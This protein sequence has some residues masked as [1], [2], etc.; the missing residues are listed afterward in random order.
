MKEISRDG[1]IWKKRMKD[2]RIKFK[3]FHL[4]FRLEMPIKVVQLSI[5]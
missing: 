2:K 1:S 5:F 3:A 4:N